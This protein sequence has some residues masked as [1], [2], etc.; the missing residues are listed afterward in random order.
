MSEVVQTSCATPAGTAITACEPFAVAVESLSG[1]KKVH[2]SEFRAAALNSSPVSS[3]G[4]AAVVNDWSAEV[5]AF[6]S[7]SADRTWKW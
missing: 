4:Q 7:A 5:A 2:R 6:P 1:L 3:V